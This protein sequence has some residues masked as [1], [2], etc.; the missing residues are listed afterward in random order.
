MN[1]NN[2][3]GMPGPATREEFEHNV[4]LTVEEVTS[5]IEKGIKDVGL[6]HS[7][8][9]KLRKVKLLPNQRINLNTVDEGLRLHSNMNN[10]MNSD[11]FQNVLRKA[12]ENKE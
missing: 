8:V 6:F 1:K 11:F 2:I 3:G 5:K 10:W 4:F 9:P 12:Q 7:I